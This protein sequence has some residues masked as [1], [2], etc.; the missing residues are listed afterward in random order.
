MIGIFFAF[1]KRNFM[2]VYS[3]YKLVAWCCVMG[4]LTLYGSNVDIGSILEANAVSA[5]IEVV[6]YHQ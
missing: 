2:S 4:I 3:S 5:V 1:G 6:L